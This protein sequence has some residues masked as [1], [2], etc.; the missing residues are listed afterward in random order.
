[1]KIKIDPEIFD[2]AEYCNSETA[3]CINLDLECLTPS[4]EI[5]HCKKFGGIEYKDRVELTFDET[6]FLYLKCEECKKAYQEAKR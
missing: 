6:E 4:N 3:D 5:T 2:D 1:M